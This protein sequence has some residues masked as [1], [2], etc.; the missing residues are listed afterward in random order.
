[1]PMSLAAALALAGCGGST[2]VDTAKLKQ[3]FQGAPPN[4][5][6]QVDKAIASLGAKQ[7]APALLALRDAVRQ[8]PP[9]PE[10]SDALTDIIK[11][12]QIIV[13]QNPKYDSP[14]TYQAIEEL[15]AALEGRPPNVM[16]KQAEP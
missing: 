5:K 6:S 14:A 7:F 12:V 11:Q 10:Q 9:T 16:R 13:A 15:D 3:S 2:Q 1:M 4:A 8:G